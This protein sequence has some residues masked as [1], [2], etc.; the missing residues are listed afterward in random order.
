MLVESRWFY[1]ATMLNLSLIN[2]GLLVRDP[3]HHRMQQRRRVPKST[4][5]HVPRGQHSERF[6]FV[7]SVLSGR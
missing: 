3:H 1:E 4:N 5:V 6:T 7:G 2:I